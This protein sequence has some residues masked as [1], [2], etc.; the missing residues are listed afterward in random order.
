MPS[1]GTLEFI[2][3]APDMWDAGNPP[4]LRFLYKMEPASSGVAGAILLVDA[5]IYDTHVS[6]QPRVERV[7]EYL[8]DAAGMMSGVL[9]F[10]LVPGDEWEG[11]YEVRLVGSAMSTPFGPPAPVAENLHCIGIMKRKNPL[12]VGTPVQIRFGISMMGMIT[13]FHA[14]WFGVGPAEAWYWPRSL[15]SVE[16]TGKRMPPPFDKLSPVFQVADRDDGHGTPRYKI[17]EG[18]A[19]VDASSRDGRVVR[20]AVVTQAVVKSQGRAAPPIF[21]TGVFSEGGGGGGIGS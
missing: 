14:W 2:Q 4:E 19:G 1:N 7:M 10:S 9:K 3:P 18:H 13:Y 8:M 5:F 15:E 17:P 6:T 20:S 11:T 16:F 12:V 21:Q